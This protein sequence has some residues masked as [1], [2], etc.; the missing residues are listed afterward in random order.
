MPQLLKLSESIT[1]A[2]ERP[3][4]L[5]REGGGDDF[6]AVRPFLF[7]LCLFEHDFCWQLGVWP[8]PLRAGAPGSGEP[9]A[10]SVTMASAWSLLYV[11]SP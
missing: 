4:H 11:S 5:R 3:G 1:S 6:D 7:S 2:A 10:S 8:V 9:F